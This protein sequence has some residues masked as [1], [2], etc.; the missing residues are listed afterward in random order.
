MVITVSFCTQKK[1]IKSKDTI[2]SLYNV[3]QSHIKAAH[4]TV[5]TCHY[6]SM[7]NTIPTLN[8]GKYIKHSHVVP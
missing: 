3:S 4:P 8:D 2:F 6:I 5:S 7:G 1:K